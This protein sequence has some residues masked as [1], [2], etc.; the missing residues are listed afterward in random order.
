KAKIESDSPEVGS[1]YLL[2]MGLEPGEYVIRGLSSMAR[3]FPINGFYFAPLHSKLSAKTPGIFYLGHVEATIRERQD[4]EFKAGPSIPLIDQAIAGGSTGTFDIV[5]SDQWAQDE[6][7]FR[8]RFP[9]LKDAVI[10]KALLL[11]FDR[12]YAQKW[13]EQN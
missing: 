2:R 10:E 12:E 11:P 4:P 8:S 1:T 9:A 13:W 3:S 6:Q 7:K 5:I